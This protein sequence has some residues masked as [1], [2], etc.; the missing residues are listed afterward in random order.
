MKEHLRFARKCM[1]ALIMFCC[2]GMHSLR[3]QPAMFAEPSAGKQSAV[4][5]NR[6]RNY[7]TMPYVK[8]FHLVAAA[9]NLVLGKKQQLALNLFS[10]ANFIVDLQKVDAEG[11]DN[12]WT[13]RVVG[14]S[15]SQVE[16]FYD[17]KIVDGNVNVGDKLFTLIG[18]DGLVL[19]RE[20]Y[21]TLL[22]KLKNDE[23]Q[24]PKK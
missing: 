17:G 10:D 7:T 15:L 24:I 19:I 14:D 12:M 4:D 3:A 21:K 22:P 8:R 18:L 1:F 13:G 16:L 2:V 5:Q 11:V 20:A 9:G 6:Y 23:R